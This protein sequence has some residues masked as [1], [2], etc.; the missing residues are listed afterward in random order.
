MNQEVRDNLLALDQH[1]HDGTGGDGAKILE[2]GV[3]RFTFTDA[4]APAAPGA[5]LTVIYTTSGEI[6]YRAGAGG[7]DVQISNANHGHP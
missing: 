1:G 6:H 2:N 3:T 4:V 5:G 7:S